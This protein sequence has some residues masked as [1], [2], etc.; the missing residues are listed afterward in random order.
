MRWIDEEGYFLAI[1]ALGQHHRVEIDQARFEEIQTASANLQHILALEEQWAAV[2][3]NYM[4]LEKGLLEAA[5][6]H[7]VMADYEWQT[8][9]DW[10]LS[11]AVRMANLLSSCRAYLD[12]TTHHLGS[13][14]PDGGDATAF[15]EARSREYDTRLG[16]RFMEAMRNYSQHRGLPLHGSSYAISRQEPD[17]LQ[18]SVATSIDLSQ[19][20][21]DDA[22]KQTVLAEISDEEL[23]VEPLLRDYMAGLSAVHLK[24]RNLLKERVAVWMEVIRGA[25]AQHVD[26]SPDGKTPG[27]SAIELGKRNAW[28]QTVHLGEDMLQ[29]I[30]IL[31]KRHRTLERVPSSFVS[32][33]PR[34]PKRKR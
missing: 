20:Q 18:Y 9:H 26:S 17:L 5:L 4:E 10:Q 24:A 15:K 7:M 23:S 27:L 32:G 3:Q 25:I 34:P 13:L 11:F 16:Y 33:A 30:E 1:R 28:L 2:I 31:Q 21:G 6:R 19:L 8:L 22:F 14:K 12:Q 29:R